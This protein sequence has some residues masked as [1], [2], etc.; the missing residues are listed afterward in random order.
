MEADIVL[1]VVNRRIKAANFTGGNIGPGPSHSAG[2]AAVNFEARLD[3][4]EGFS[5]FLT[6]P[7]A[8]SAISGGDNCIIKLI[9]WENL[10]AIDN[11]Y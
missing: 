8:G 6:A 7:K 5:Q 11:S 2:G 1:P 3:G 10:M 9:A 4:I